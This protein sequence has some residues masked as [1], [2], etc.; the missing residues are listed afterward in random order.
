MYKNTLTIEADLNRHFSRYDDPLFD[1]ELEVKD[2][3]RISINRKKDG[4]RISILKNE[5][6]VYMIDSNKLTKKQS[7]FLQT[8][9]GLQ[10]VLT[11]YKKG[12]K[13]ISGLKK[14]LCEL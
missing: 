10:F 6:V 9:A 12:V 4:Y 11:Q 14:A 13:N 5:E 2:Y 7:N 8:G 1:D 3:I